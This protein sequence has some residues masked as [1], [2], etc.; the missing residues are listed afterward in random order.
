MMNQLGRDATT[1]PATKPGQV[2]QLPYLVSRVSCGAFHTMAVVG[3]GLLQH[4]IYKLFEEGFLLKR[5]FL[6]LF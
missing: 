5:L 1:V 2:L 6:I 4:E 3:D